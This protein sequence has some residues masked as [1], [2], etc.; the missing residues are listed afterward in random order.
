MDDGNFD[1]FTRSLATVRSRRS[2]MRTFGGGLVGGLLGLAGGVKRDLAEA[3]VAPRSEDICIWIPVLKACIIPRRPVATCPPNT[4]CSGTATCG[5]Y[6]TAG[7]CCRYPNTAVCVCDSSPDA[8][9]G[10]AVCC[11]PEAGT[12]PQ[13]YYATGGNKATAGKNQCCDVPGATKPGCCT[14]CDPGDTATSCPV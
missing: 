14:Q 12:C 8:G 9:D 1:A 13:R 5:A 6:T 7:L 3:D 2:V 11:N 4:Y 10:F